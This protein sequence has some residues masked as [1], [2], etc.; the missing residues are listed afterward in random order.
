MPFLPWNQSIIDWN[1][2]EIVNQNK[3]VLEMQCVLLDQQESDW[4]KK[5]EPE[6]QFF[7]FFLTTLIFLT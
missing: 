1:F 5:L 4:C 7:F 6:E 3:P 2:F